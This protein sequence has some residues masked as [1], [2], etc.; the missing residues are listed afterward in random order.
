ME[1]KSDQGPFAAWVED[2]TSDQQAIV[3]RVE[4]GDGQMPRVEQIPV[5]ECGGRLCIGQ[6]VDVIEVQGDDGMIHP[7]L[8]RAS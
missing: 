7:Q 5:Q 4:H 1:Y 6:S 3:L 2:Y 8:K